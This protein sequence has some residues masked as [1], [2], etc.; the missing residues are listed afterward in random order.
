MREAAERVAAEARRV[1][2]RLDPSAP[3]LPAVASSGWF[4]PGP[5][6]RGPQDA[7]PSF[8]ETKGPPL[9]HPPRERIE[10]RVPICEA[11]V[12]IPRPTAPQL[13]GTLTF[14]LSRQ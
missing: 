12:Q 5:T 14:I 7:T 2:K 6:P 9:P 10:V 8:G 1:D 4:G 11:T 13:L 3:H